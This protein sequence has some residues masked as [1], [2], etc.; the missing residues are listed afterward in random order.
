MIDLLG[1]YEEEFVE[2][3]RIASGEFGVVKKARH[4]LDGMVYAIKMTKKPLKDN[5]RSEK[6]AMKEIFAGA[7]MMKHKH[8]V[9]W[10][11]VILCTIAKKYFST[12]YKYF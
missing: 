10:E 12:I 2:I 3:E 7:A 5:S 11:R 8:V 6:T 4:R 9:R 1:R